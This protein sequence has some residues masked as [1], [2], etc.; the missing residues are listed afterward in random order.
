[1]KKKRLLK[2]ANMLEVIDPSMFD[3]SRWAHHTECGTKYCVM[4]FCAH[5]GLFEN[6]AFDSV[7]QNL[8][9]KQGGKDWYNWD[10]I[11]CLFDITDADAE[12]LFG[13]DNP[14]SPEEIAEQIRFFVKTGKT[15]QGDE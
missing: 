13:V 6:F 15:E 4:G 1:M 5:L 2:V 10:G 11:T 8:I 7:M 9:Y 3:I 12:C 14:R